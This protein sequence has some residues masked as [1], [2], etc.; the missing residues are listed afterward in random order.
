[1]VFADGLIGP[2]ARLIP[3]HPSISSPPNLLHLSH[4]S[5]LL[6]SPPPTQR[7]GSSRREWLIDGRGLHPRELP[8]LQGLLPGAAPPINLFLFEERPSE[9]NQSVLATF[10]VASSQLILG[11]SSVARKHI[12]AEMGL[13]FEVMVGLRR[14]SLASC[15]LPFCIFAPLFWWDFL[16]SGLS[17]GGW[18]DSVVSDCRYRREE[19][20]EGEPWRASD[21]SCGG[22]GAAFSSF[23]FFPISLDVF[24]AS[25]LASH[26]HR[27]SSKCVADSMSSAMYY[28]YL[29]QN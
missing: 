24:T 9:S 10:A 21:G 20:Q 5:P 1:M 27:Y 19:H 13:E 25:A 22:Q 14:F 16:L 29:V 11:S 28:Y 12:L 26:S 3:T 18:T 23:V 2:V 17:L 8:A 15:P 4:T 7:L 6:P